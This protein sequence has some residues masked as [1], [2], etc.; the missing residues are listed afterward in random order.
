MK[1]RYWVLFAS[2]SSLVALAAA[3]VLVNSRMRAEF[4]WLRFHPEVGDVGKPAMIPA[5]GVVLYYFHINVRC[6]TCRDME[7]YAREL[8]MDRFG[9]RVVAGD[10]HWIPVNV[11]Q[12]ANRHFLSDFQ[13]LTRSLVLEHRRDGR[14]LRSKVLQEA[15]LHLIDRAEFDDYLSSEIDGF[16]AES[17]G[18]SASRKE[19]QVDDASGSDQAKGELR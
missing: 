18:V 12:P 9:S 19:L 8:V 7:R 1:T 16:L 3:V 4:P 6:T 10:L 15:W 5:N 17:G 2:I 11:Q 14:T 13:T